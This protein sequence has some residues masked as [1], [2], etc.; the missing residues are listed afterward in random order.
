MIRWLAVLWVCFA[1]AL[2]PDSAR[3]DELRPAYI[4]MT[5]QAPGQW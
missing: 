2:V 5:E 1:L 3:A 4:E